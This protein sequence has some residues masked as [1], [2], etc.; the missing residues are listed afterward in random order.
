MS[1][2]KEQQ[3]K[4][5]KL[6]S[7]YSDN[8]GV[9]NSFE[10]SGSVVNS[11]G[12]N[13][14]NRAYLRETAIVWFETFDLEQDTY[15][16]RHYELPFKKLVDESPNKNEDDII[17]MMFDESYCK[18]NDQCASKNSIF[19]FCRYDELIDY[20]YELKEDSSLS[21]ISKLYRYLKSL[22]K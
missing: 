18:E 4:I 2:T 20:V 21:S 8:C 14:L 11:C 13:L 1:Y 16:V 10:V 5:I 19:S 3:S 7:E 6:L 15:E 22:E 17:K 12:F 9:R